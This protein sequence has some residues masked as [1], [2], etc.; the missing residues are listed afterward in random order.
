[1]ESIINPGT[2]LPFV[3]R[4]QD[5]AVSLCGGQGSPA[6]TRALTTTLPRYAYDIAHA[7]A[8]ARTRQLLSHVTMCVH[9]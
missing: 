8:L 7:N 6:S 2:F 5:S 9:T 3:H 4:S 1:M